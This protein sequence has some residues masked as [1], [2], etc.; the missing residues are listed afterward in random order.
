M[1]IFDVMVG[2]GDFNLL[3]WVICVLNIVV[4][5]LVSR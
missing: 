2:L 4:V 5:E 1:L 3:G